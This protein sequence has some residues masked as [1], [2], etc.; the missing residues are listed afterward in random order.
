VRL[1]VAAVETTIMGGMDSMKV[2]YS[3]SLTGSCATQEV[4]MIVSK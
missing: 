3:V 4:A 1:S 2:A